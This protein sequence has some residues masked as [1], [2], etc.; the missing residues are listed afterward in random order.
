MSERVRERESETVSGRKLMGCS[1]LHVCQ[2]EM[3]CLI[4]NKTLNQLVGWCIIFYSA[5]YIHT[6]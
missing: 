6:S 4:A 3:T 1:T 5:Q 2:Y